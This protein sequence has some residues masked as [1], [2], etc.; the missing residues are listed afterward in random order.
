MVHIVF[1]FLPLHHVILTRWRWRRKHL[2]YIISMFLTLIQLVS[3][4][5]ILDPTFL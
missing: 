5:L 2:V 4:E 1:K 3:Q